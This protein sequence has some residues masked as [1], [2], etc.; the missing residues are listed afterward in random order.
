MKAGL[1]REVIVIEIIINK[2]NRS[3]VTRKTSADGTGN[4]G[5]GVALLS[6]PVLG[7][8]GQVFMAPA[9]V[10]H[11]IQL[12]LERGHDFG[13]GGFLQPRAKLFGIRG[14]SFSCE[15][16]LVIV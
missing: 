4:C 6:C 10:H 9:S 7:Q 5:T 1:D 12:P 14:L 16:D 3:R 11:W 13:Q 2:R 15:K 8:G